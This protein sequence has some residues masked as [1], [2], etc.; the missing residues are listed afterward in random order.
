MVGKDSLYPLN[1]NF[2]VMDL[3]NMIKIK[4]LFIN[5]NLDFIIKLHLLELSHYLKKVNAGQVIYAKIK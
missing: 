3:I 2:N 5:Q 4:I 1:L